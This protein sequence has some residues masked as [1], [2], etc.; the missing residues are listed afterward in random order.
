MFDD[1]FTSANIVPLS[2][3]KSLPCN[4]GFVWEC[5]RIWKWMYLYMIWLQME[6]VSD[7]HHWHQS[8]ST[9]ISIDN[10]ITQNAINKW[11]ISVHNYCILSD[12]VLNI[13]TFRDSNDCCCCCLCWSI[14][15][16]NE[17]KIA[18]CSQW[19]AHTLTHT[20]TKRERDI[21]LILCICVVN[22]LR[23]AKRKRYCWL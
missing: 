17:S 3:L 10:G 8:N 21:I 5:V 1:R 11:C 14:E 23:T 19:H 6:R 20:L 13:H 7:S 4:F 9:G 2:A 22:C 15:Q 16:A 18:E 12:N